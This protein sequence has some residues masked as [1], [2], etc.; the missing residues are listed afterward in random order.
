[1]KILGRVGIEWERN[2]VKISKM[3]EEKLWLSQYTNSQMEQKRTKKGDKAKN[4]RKG[5]ESCG[6]M[7][8][9]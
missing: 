1:M 9:S 7:R 3:N 5:A 4:G 8:F 6:I 2:Q